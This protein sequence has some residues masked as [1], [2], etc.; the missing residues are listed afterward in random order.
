MLGLNMLKTI[1]T[2]SLAVAL[3]TVTAFVVAIWLYDSSTSVKIENL[4]DTSV[5]VTAKWKDKAKVVGELAPTKTATFTVSSEAAMSFV[6][7]YPSGKEI[8]TEGYY[9]TSGTNL[10]LEIFN[11]AVEVSVGS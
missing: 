10:N 3:A 2:A 8:T 7:R 6:V 4:S 5:F 11:Q 1:F 9:F